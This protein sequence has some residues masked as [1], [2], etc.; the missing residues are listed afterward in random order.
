[1]MKIT[2]KGDYMFIYLLNPNNTIFIVS[3]VDYNYEKYILPTDSSW[4]F[5]IRAMNQ[6][7]VPN[8]YGIAMVWFSF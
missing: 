1:M 5:S 4:Y 3:I 7:G 6:Q 8:C 2:L